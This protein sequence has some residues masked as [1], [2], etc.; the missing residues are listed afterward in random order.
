[1]PF[2]PLST[3]ALENDPAVKLMYG[4]NH[5]LNWQHAMRIARCN[6]LRVACYQ[7]KIQVQGFGARRFEPCWPLV[8]R[9]YATNASAVVMLHHAPNILET[10]TRNIS[11]PRDVGATGDADNGLFL[12]F[13]SHVTTLLPLVGTRVNSTKQLDA[14]TQAPDTANIFV[15]L[16]EHAGQRTSLEIAMST[17]CDNNASVAMVTRSQPLFHSGA[18]HLAAAATPTVYTIYAAFSECSQAN[19][20]CNSRLLTS[21][22]VYICNVGLCVSCLL[23]THGCVGLAT[24]AYSA[25]YVFAFAKV[26][27]TFNCVAFV[28]IY[29]VHP[30][31]MHG[32][33]INLN[34]GHKA[35]FNLLHLVQLLLHSWSFSATGSATILITFSRECTRNSLLGSFCFLSR[36]STATF[37]SKT[38]QS[39]CAPAS[40]L[41]TSCT[42]RQE[43]RTGHE[44]TGPNQ[45]QGPCKTHFCQQC[46]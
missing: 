7:W 29:F 28:C 21:F 19:G 27:V 10:H 18:I 39:T 33:P 36:C 5:D 12:H 35:V 32:G 14:M 24:H 37:T 25:V 34:R 15:V 31:S 9:V 6:S 42:S 38:V 26:V 46:F 17:R 40:S 23:L 43:T 3:Y 4:G 8:S 22:A 45:S 44:T 16:P 2:I 11:I 41:H 30:A 20:G 1:V 13:S